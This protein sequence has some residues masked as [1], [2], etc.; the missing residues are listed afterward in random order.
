SFKSRKNKN[1][2]DW[3][4][5]YE[6]TK[7]IMDDPL[8]DYDNLVDFHIVLVE[9]IKL[10]SNYVQGQLPGKKAELEK[11][12]KQAKKKLVSDAEKEWFEVYLETGQEQYSSFVNKQV[13]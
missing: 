12:V 7:M 6:L 11:L 3:E 1:I 8:D 10:K 2:S 5:L 4:K 9:V 13:E